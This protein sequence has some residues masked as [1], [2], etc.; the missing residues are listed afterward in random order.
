MKEITIKYIN[1]DEPNYKMQ[2][3]QNNKG[4]VVQVLIDGEPVEDLEYFKTEFTPD[5][6]PVIIIGR[7]LGS[8]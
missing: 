1:F 8:S 2:R 4:K 6:E 3:C 7:S 5:K